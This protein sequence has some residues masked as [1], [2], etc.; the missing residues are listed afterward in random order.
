[1]PAA[2]RLGPVMLAAAARRRMWFIHGL[3]VGRSRR[4]LGLRRLGRAQNLRGSRLGCLRRHRCLGLVPSLRRGRRRGLHPQGCS[5][6][7][8][9]VCGWRRGPLRACGAR[10]EWGV[11]ALARGPEAPALA[12]R[13]A[14][15]PWMVGIRVLVGSNV[16][17]LKAF[18]LG[19]LLPV[20]D[21]WA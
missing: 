17:G 21:G 5:R 4:L 9:G 6:W 15:P 12:C 1:M 18:R 10:R 3:H 7:G 19:R 8:S 13:G 20:E 16:P 2:S 11:G 14:A